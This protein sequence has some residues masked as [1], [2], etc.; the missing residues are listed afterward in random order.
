[1]LFRS[2]RHVAILRTAR[3]EWQRHHPVPA[4]VHKALQA[5]YNTVTQALE[6][7]LQAEYAKQE[8]RKQALI[9]QAAALIDAAEVRS[10]CETAKNLQQQWKETGSCGH[11]RD[12]KLWEEFRAHC[13]ALFAR[14]EEERT[15]HKNEEQDMVDQAARLLDQI[16]E[17]LATEGGD[18]VASAL[19]EA[20]ESLT[21]TVHREQQ[22][23]LRA[24][25]A[26]I[27][28]RIESGRAAAV[29]A[30]FRTD[31]ARLA[32]VMALLQQAEEAVLSGTSA[33]EAAAGVDAAGFP[34]TF[35]E[36]LGKRLAHLPRT[37]EVEPGQQLQLFNHHCLLLEILLDLPSPAEE[38]ALRV[39]RQMT[40]F[41][42]QRYPKT[43]EEKQKLVR[44]TLRAAVVCPSLPAAEAPAALER[45]AA[46]TGSE[47]FLSL[48]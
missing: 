17:V 30:G 15:A 19:I 8:A 47:P 34:A 24:R 48:F 26:D 27:R 32:G 44:N 22:A 45:L 2:Q 38:Q 31:V 10:A 12:Q 43:A 29:Q 46:I 40:L 4:K 3:E 42:L 21:L 23:A 28:R 18:E 41:K 33:D 9:T 35:A 37:A 6:D 1:V 7:K 36:E 13:D 39:S 11:V 5:R 25:L 20:F 16:A 14:R